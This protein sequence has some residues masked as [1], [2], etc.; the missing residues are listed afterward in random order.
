[1]AGVE[2]SKEEEE[3]DVVVVVVV[4]KHDAYKLT[5]PQVIMAGTNARTH[6]LNL[7]YWS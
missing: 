4:T 5:C 7:A 3:E 6:V 1:M 2:S